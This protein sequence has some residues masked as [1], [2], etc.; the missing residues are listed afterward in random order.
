MGEEQVE[1]YQERMKGYYGIGDFSKNE[2]AKILCGLRPH[3]NPLFS[4]HEL[5]Y[6]CPL[7]G[8]SDEVNLHF[9]E[10]KMFLW[11]KKCN[12]DIPSCLCVKYPEPKLH[13]DHTELPPKLKIKQAT[14]IFLDCLEEVQ[15]KDANDESR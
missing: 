6:A 7:C 14:K 11:C 10:Y 15:R 4:P 8:A 13:L 12:L 1:K 2:R 9:S 5:G 3:G